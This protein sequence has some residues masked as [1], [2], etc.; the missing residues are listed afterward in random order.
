MAAIIDFDKASYAR[1]DEALFAR[2]S[3]DLLSKGYSINLNA[4]PLHLANE[5]YQHVSLMPDHSFEE[6]AIGR[7]QKFVKNVFV[8]SQE[9]RWITGDSAV[10]S[11]WLQWTN[12]MQRYL[13]RRVFLGL[14]SFESHYSRYRL[15]DFYKRHYDAFNG[16]TSRKVSIVVYLNRDWLVKDGGELVLYKDGK[17][18]I[19]VKVTPSFATVVVFLS[20]DYPHEVLPTQRDRYSIAGWFSPNTT[21]SSRVNPP[22]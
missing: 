7:D 18:R 16:E 1:H 5:L 9:L 10:G 8:R 6:A 14:F 17:D 3:D 13:N 15:G 12:D 21:T 19:G 11:N 2:I 4:L 20:S 22:T